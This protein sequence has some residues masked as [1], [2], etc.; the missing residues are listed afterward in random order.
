MIRILALIAGIG[1]LVSIVCLG[2]AAPSAATTFATAG[3]RPP[4]GASTFVMTMV[5]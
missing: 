5:T 3:T 1:F 4:T 2:G